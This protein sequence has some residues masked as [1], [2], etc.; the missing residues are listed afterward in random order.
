MMRRRGVGLS[1]KNLLNAGYP[2]S[3][4]VVRTLVE[5]IPEEVLKQTT[6]RRKTG[7]FREEAEEIGLDQESGEWLSNEKEG[8]KK[9]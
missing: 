1:D 9:R 7:S 5:K 8:E 4:E 3:Q 2:D 6:P